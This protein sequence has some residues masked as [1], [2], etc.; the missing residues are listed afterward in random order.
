MREVWKRI[1]GITNSPSASQPPDKDNQPRANFP[2]GELV[3]EARKGD[4]ENVIA[5]GCLR[6]R[7]TETRAA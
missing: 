1:R 7:E 5:C 2:A 3:L 4:N 6:K